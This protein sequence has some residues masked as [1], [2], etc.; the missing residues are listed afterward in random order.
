[1][2][3]ND[4]LT[5]YQMSPE[6]E[7]RFSKSVIRNLKG[8]V[9]INYGSYVMPIFLLFIL[10]SLLEMFCSTHP[11]LLSMVLIILYGL[12][13]VVILWYMLSWRLEFDGSTGFL[14]YYTLFRGATTYHIDEMM[15]FTVDVQRI[16]RAERIYRF[17]RRGV[18]GAVGLLYGEDFL[19]SFRARRTLRIRELL[20]IHTPEGTITIPISS[21]WLTSKMVHGAGGYRDAEKLCSYL[22]LY[23]RFVYK[24]NDTMEL[25][26]EEPEGLSPAVR[27]A[28]EAQQKADA[29]AV[30]EVQTIPE[31]IPEEH[32]PLLD[33]PARAPEKHLSVPDVSVPISPEPEIRLPKPSQT[34]AP[35]TPAS[36]EPQPAQKSAFPDPAQKPSADVDALFDQVLRQ[37]GKKR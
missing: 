5:S 36:P 21:S 24:H 19:E 2:P 3:I 16:Q 34:P 20:Q 13:T 12:M 27:Q 25:Y 4:I 37:Y 17:G 35:P 31:L 11:G 14:S 8:T 9:R 26:R 22:D 6:A 15:S 18:R 7:A 23:R 33:L 10:G 1:M 29:Q 32:D 30:P 28:I